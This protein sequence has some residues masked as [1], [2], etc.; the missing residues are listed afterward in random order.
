MEV[1]IEADGLQHESLDR[2]QCRPVCLLCLWGSQSS[3]VG[4]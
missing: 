2:Y 1:E 3:V 4:S